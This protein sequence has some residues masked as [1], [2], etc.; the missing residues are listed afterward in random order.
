ML[1]AGVAGPAPGCGFAPRY[2]DFPSAGFATSFILN[3]LSL[4]LCNSLNSKGFSDFCG[5]Q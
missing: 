5:F 1:I 2:F 4:Y 3:G